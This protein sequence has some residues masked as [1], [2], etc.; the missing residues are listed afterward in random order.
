MI[1][2]KISIHSFCDNYKREKI[3]Q[4]EYNV[5]SFAFELYDS[6]ENPVNISECISA[7][8]YGTKAD[9]TLIGNECEIADNKV[10]ITP[11]LQMTAC[12]GLL[13]GIIECQFESGNI[14][15]Y[16]IDF[17][18][19]PAPVK[20]E[21]ASTDEFTVFDRTLAEVR[22]LLL[23]AENGEFNGAD[24]INGTN[25][26][27]GKDGI[28]IANAEINSAGEL[29]LTY[30]DGTSV[31][32]G[33]VV[34][35]DGKDGQDGADVSDEVEDIKAY[36]GYT[37]SDILGL[38]VD[39][40]NKT[41]TR[42]AG[43]VGL[44][45]GADF[46][47]FAMYG[48]RK[49]CNVSD[50]GTITAYYGD[51]NYAEDGSNGQVMVYQ[52]KFY[53][54][55]VPLKLEPIEGG[56]GY[57][58]RKTN[59]YISATPKLGFKLHP[60]FYDVNGNEVDYILFS[61]YEGS[62]YD[63]SA[64]EYVNDGTNTNTAIETGDLLCSIAGVK[65]ISGLYKKLTKA[66][67]EL[68]AQNRNSGWR[69]ETVKAVSAN[70]LLMMIELGTMNTQTA[71]GKGVVSI[72]DSRGYNCASLTGST[73]EL[74]NCTGQATVTINEIGGV[75]T[76]YTENGEVSVSY[77]GMENPWG[78]VLKQI[79][80]VNI[81]GDGTMFGGQP[82][83]ADDFNFG[84][85][86]ITDN[87]KP[88]GF[89]IPNSSGYISALGYGSEEYDWLLMPSENKGTSILP[90]GDISSATA[91]LNGYR[92]ALLGGSWDYNERAGVFCWAYYGAAGGFSR[93]IGGRLM[94]VPTAN[95]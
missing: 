21:I 66:N 27:N 58:Q 14:R 86:K 33:M 89:T 24:G 8:Y 59:F 32:L 74:G 22:E 40:E 88:A 49:R 1:L 37:D 70:Q 53:Y 25:G 31:N 48:G 78:N 26:A 50:D 85:I 90:V 43:A 60:A 69:L 30:S 2:K 92:I 55:V 5:G 91:N 34:G 38:Q 45:A 42:L 9:G 47:Q 81:W 15:F 80:G 51:E 28:G 11:T 6:K 54:K 35:A 79:N 72:T 29:I 71:I 57:H 67:L 13:K 73:S 46:D 20:A 12:A 10:I 83:I 23:K 62:M 52:P 4:Y 36:I 65:P 76:A 77:R 75:E 7:V 84:E 68:L 94:Y 44:S 64:A 18:I 61:A 3:T 93:N 41:F 56:I 16:G 17:E 39:F 87:Y 63:F 95:V 82:Y 19:Q